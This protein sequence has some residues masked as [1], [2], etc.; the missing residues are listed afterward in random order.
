VDR[1]PELAT[2][3][4]LSE[5]G[6]ARRLPVAESEEWARAFPHGRLVLIPDAGHYPQAEQPTPVG[7]GFR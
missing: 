4:H 6:A 7:I 3:N 5:V 2:H 1:I